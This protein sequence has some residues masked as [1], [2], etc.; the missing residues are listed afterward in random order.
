M[1]VVTVIV[2]HQTA[3]INLRVISFDFG[4]WISIFRPTLKYLKNRLQS[5]YHI[6]ITDYDDE[7]FPYSNTPVFYFT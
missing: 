1:F 3:N 5:I 7:S 2:I 4:C 6:R